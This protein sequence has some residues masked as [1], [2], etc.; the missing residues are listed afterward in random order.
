[1]AFDDEMRRLSEEL[2]ATIGDMMK[3]DVESAL[4]WVVLTSITSNTTP[5]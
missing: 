5:D 1:M 3:G 2:H 4:K